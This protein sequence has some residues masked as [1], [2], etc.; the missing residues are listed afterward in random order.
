MPQDA[1]TIKHIVTK[2]NSIV[3][4]AKV[5]KINQPFRDMIVLSLYTCNGSRKLEISANPSDARISLTELEYANPLTAPN[6]CMLLRKYILGSTIT[7]V[8]QVEGERIVIL[9]FDCKNEFF[10]AKRELYIEIM[11]KYSNIVLTENGVILGAMKSS[12]LEE[13]YKRVLFS[14]V[15]YILPEP[16]EKVSILDSEKVS[17]LFDN[18][19]GGDI[20]KFLF[21]NVSGIASSTAYELCNIYF[22]GTNPEKLRNE[23][24]INFANYLKDSYFADYNDCSIKIVENEYRDFFCFK[25]S[26]DKKIF[27]DLFEAQD[28]FY[29]KKFEKKSFNDSSRKLLS[30]AKAQ[31]KKLEKKLALLVD[32]LRECSNM[33]QNK[34][35]GELITSNIYSIKKGDKVC[36]VYNYYE[37]NSPLIKINLDETLSPSQNAQQFFKK[38]NKQKRTILAIEPQKTEA[39]R[40]LE[41]IESIISSINNAENLNDLKEIEEELVDIGLIKIQQS[42]KQPKKS[43]L[44][45]R[46]FEIDGFKVYA[47]R[48]NI[49]ND[50]L[51]KLANENDIWLHTQKYHSSHLI[52]VLDDKELTNEVLLTAGE[53]CASLSAGKNGDKI[54]VD[55][56]QKRFVKKPNKAKHGF[57][58]YTNFKTILVTPNRHLEKEKV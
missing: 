45:F 8:T 38:Y 48:N 13:H 29:S 11:G 50:R 15:K 35:K 54:P 18:F 52:I 44:P 30:I 57:V 17:A 55:Y 9:S 31:A 24:S 26:G 20:S 25:C 36:E 1:F 12:T 32:R 43:V 27:N 41:Y 47:G 33:E 23:E 19:M 39:Q 49:Q 7:Q 46:E 42:K 28:F 21:E 2:L 5:N 3:E 53:I 4:G 51:L 34:L 40:E 16:Q 56:C 58:N 37:E 10:N 22:K 14:G 6:F